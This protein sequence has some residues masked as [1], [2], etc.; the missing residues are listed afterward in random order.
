V[1]KENPLKMLKEEQKSTNLEDLEKWE[2][3]YAT[4]QLVPIVLILATPI[5][6]LNF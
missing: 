3:F 2:I 4:V 1:Y 5:A 6:N